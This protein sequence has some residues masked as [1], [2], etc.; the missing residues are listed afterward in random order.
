MSMPME[1]V[2]RSKREEVQGL[3][4]DHEILGAVTGKEWQNGPKGSHIE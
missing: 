1:W 4:E 3:N 2:Y